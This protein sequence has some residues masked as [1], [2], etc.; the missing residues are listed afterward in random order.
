MIEPIK[1]VNPTQSTPIRPIFGKVVE[2]KRGTKN[3]EYS[4][5]FIQE[6]VFT[7]EDGKYTVTQTWEPKDG[8][9]LNML[10]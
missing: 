4:V 8:Q 6:E 2:T 7:N 5:R 10:G 9:K 3:D 1:P